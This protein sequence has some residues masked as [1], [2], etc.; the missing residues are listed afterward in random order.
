MIEAETTPVHVGRRTQLWR[1]EMRSDGKLVAVCS[2]RT[3][4]MDA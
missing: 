2:L 1:T 4:V 3:M